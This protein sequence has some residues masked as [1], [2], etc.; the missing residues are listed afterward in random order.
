MKKQLILASIMALVAAHAGTP[1]S[2]IDKGLLLNQPSVNFSNGHSTINLANGE[3]FKIAG[4]GDRV[5]FQNIATLNWQF[6]QPVVRPGELQ[7]ADLA[8]I[9]ADEIMTITAT[10]LHD[11]A[12]QYQVHVIKHLQGNHARLRVLSVGQ[13]PEPETFALIAGCLAF[14]SIAL[15]RR[16][17]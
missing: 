15:K 9:H 11:A 14:T 2:Q 13:I 5:E 16:T 3:K 1:V 6:S 10:A 8:D 4:L 12:Q 17:A 7:F